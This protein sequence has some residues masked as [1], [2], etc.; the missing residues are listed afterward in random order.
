MILK[1]LA[2]GL[3]VLC[4]VLAH[5]GNAHLVVLGVRFLESVGKKKKQ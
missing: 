2:A 4:C 3:A 5:G 1:S